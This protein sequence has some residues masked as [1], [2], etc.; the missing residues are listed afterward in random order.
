MIKLIPV[1]RPAALTK[2]IVTQ[3]TQD[4]INEGKT[5]WKGN[6]IEEALLDMS[7]DKC[8]YCE[9]HIDEESKYLEVEHF[10]HKNQYKNLVLQWSNL[11]PSCKRCNTTKGSHDVGI[12]PIINPTIDSPNEHLCFRAYRIYPKSS[13]G[14]K[15]I[16]IINLNH[17]K[18]IVKP[19]FDLGDKLVEEL[20]VLLELSIDYDNGKS[21]HT[22][23]KN[24][25]TNK[26][27]RLM[28]EAIP[29]SE[30]AATAATILLN[31]DS[32]VAVHQIF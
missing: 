20:Y 28:E 5:V 14:K 26:L 29:S 1:P 3:L 17:R 18:R 15:T 30:F 23:R 6:G 7:N 32:F 21:H 22:R 2:P 10:Y 13:L 12:E 27:E 19:R 31:D 16:E 11:L 8:C 24:I 25:I 9:C 4:F